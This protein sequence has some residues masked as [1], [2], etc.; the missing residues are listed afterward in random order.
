MLLGNG[1]GTFSTAVSYSVGF[2]RHHGVA[3][4]DFNHNRKQ[5][6]EFITELQ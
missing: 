6:I 3:V 2:R 4:G 1:D 5:D